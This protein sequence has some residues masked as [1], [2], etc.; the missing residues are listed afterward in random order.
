VITDA[1]EGGIYIAVCATN[2]T[3][4]NNVFND[5]IAVYSNF[6][7][8]YDDFNTEE[9]NYRNWSIQ[10]NT[11]NAV[12]KNV[13]VGIYTAVASE[14]C[15]DWTIDGNTTNS[16][17]S[18]KVA[19]FLQTRGIEGDYIVTNNT[20]K[21][22]FLVIQ[23]EGIR[24]SDLTGN[25]VTGELA[26]G[27]EL[28]TYD[29]P[30]ILDALE[31][32]PLWDKVTVIYVGVGTYTRLLEVVGLDLLPT[33][34]TFSITRTKNAPHLT[35]VEIQP[36]AWNSF[37]RGYMIFSDAVL[38]LTKGAGGTID[39]V[40]WTPPTPD[41]PPNL[42]FNGQLEANL[43]PTV[44][45]S[46]DAFAGIA[47]GEAVTINHN[48]NVT[49]EHVPGVMELSTGVDFVASGSGSKSATRDAAG[50]LQITI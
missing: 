33:G 17:G 12:T 6:Q 48:G 27:Y 39:F 31:V 7:N 41:I 9:Y 3:I 19:I 25:V 23:E 32:C 49:I 45:Q 29:G 10:G 4:Q 15:S 18:F 2:V 44:A 14:A 26:N 43:F 38:V 36:A 16:T 40:S 35:G 11:I 22:S 5:T 50:I 42:G 30:E 13:S 34:F 28:Y 24:P 46:Y 21:D 47:I 8:I 1:R 37:T 20:I